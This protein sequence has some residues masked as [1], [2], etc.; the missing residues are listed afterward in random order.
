MNDSELHAWI[1]DELVWLRKRTD[2][3]SILCVVV[4]LSCGIP[5]IVSLF[6]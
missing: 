2:V 4:A 1:R 6:L 5:D 3:L